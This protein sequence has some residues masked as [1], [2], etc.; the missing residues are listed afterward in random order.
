[1]VQCS[2]SGKNVSRDDG[3]RLCGLDRGRGCVRVGLTLFGANGNCKSLS[4]PV[5]ALFDQQD[6]LVGHNWQH[7]RELRL[8]WCS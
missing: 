4:A 1:M 5:W 3:D 6:R 8:C 7:L 2:K